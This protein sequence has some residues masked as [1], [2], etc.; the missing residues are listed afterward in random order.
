[1][2]DKMSSF[3]FVHH[4]MKIKLQTIL[5]HLFN[6]SWFGSSYTK[7]RFQNIKWSNQR[8]TEE[9][10][11]MLHQMHVY[12]FLQLSKTALGFRLHGCCTEAHLRYSYWYPVQLNSV[13]SCFFWILSVFLSI[14]CMPVLLFSSILPNTQKQLM[15]Q[16]AL[17]CSPLSP[18]L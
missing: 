9:V 15:S 1:M 6:L 17:H 3:Y 13:L 2:V 5:Q 18:H 7:I 14:F 10:Y 11:H 16:Q 8:P 12:N 4:W